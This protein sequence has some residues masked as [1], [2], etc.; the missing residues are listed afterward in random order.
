[1]ILILLASL[2]TGARAD[3]AKEA[4]DLAALPAYR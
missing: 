4:F 1:M 3:D 2:P